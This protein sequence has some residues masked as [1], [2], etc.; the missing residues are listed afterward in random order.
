MLA[1]TLCACFIVNAG[2][3]RYLLQQAGGG[4]SV[5]ESDYSY[6]INVWIDYKWDINATIESYTI[7]YET[8]SSYIRS[9]IQRPLHEIQSIIDE[10]EHKQDLIYNHSSNTMKTWHMAMEVTADKESAGKQLESYAME[11]ITDDIIYIFENVTILDIIDVRCEIK[12]HMHDITWLIVGIILGLIGAAILCIC[13]LCICFRP[14]HRNYQGA[15]EAYINDSKSI[16]DNGYDPFIDGKYFGY[17]KQYGSSHPMKPFDLLF[18][19]G[20]VTGHGSDD[21]GDYNI[22]GI[23]SD[24]T[25]RIALYKA[26]IK[27][28]GDHIQ[29]LG[30]T[31]QIKV[32]YH[33]SANMFKGNWYVKESKYEKRGE[34][35][36]QL[37]TPSIMEDTT[38]TEHDGI[39]KINGY[40]V[41]KMNDYHYDTSISG[42]Y[43]RSGRNKPS[44]IDYSKANTI[45]TD[46]E[47]DAA[48]EYVKNIS[49]HSQIAQQ[50]KYQTQLEYQQF[51]EYVENMDNKS[52]PVH[53]QQPGAQSYVPVS[54][55]I[56]NADEEVYV[57]NADCDHY[58][59]KSAPAPNQIIREYGTD[60]IPGYS[61]DPF[62]DGLFS[63]YYQA[64]EN[65]YAINKFEMRFINGMITGKGRGPD[66]DYKIQ[67]IYSYETLEMSFDQI[68][69]DLTVINEYF[70]ITLKYDANKNE[71]IGNW[72][73]I[74]SGIASEEQLMVVTRC[75]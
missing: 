74:T 33:K 6:T 3:R 62:I 68:Y 61:D 27:G 41:R 45:D 32:E 20:I 73:K 60:H 63:G 49:I 42:K 25:Q 38:D 29:N 21:I 54:T 66:G 2:A 22:M 17:Y 5:S 35:I 40:D 47:Q 4:F 75:V 34:W 55:H 16:K 24:A 8:I 48:P 58:L 19:D 18:I 57:N 64:S 46:H 44:I 72:R 53:Q 70:R 69:N 26:Y 71:F 14:L 30:Q 13:L 15:N 12:A 36:I 31:V 51:M 28:T 9:L 59:V 65:M 56:S 1:T 50:L 11:D 67:G 23:Y 52:F 43:S 39:M 37:C 7:E 10:T